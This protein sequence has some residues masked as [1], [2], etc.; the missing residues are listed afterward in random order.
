GVMI[1]Y[2]SS[3]YTTTPLRVLYTVGIQ[4]S[5]KT[6]GKIDIEKVDEAYKTA[7]SN[8]DGSVNF[9]SNL[10]VKAN[11]PTGDDRYDNGAI[12]DTTV[13]FTPSIHNRYYFF[14]KNRQIY[15]DES[16]V[17]PVPADYV[18]DNHLPDG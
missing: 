7:N 11:N 3:R 1:D 17:K 16:C 8:T 5:I 6:D 14:Q 12:G 18:T 2:T 10:Y 15:F 13:Q 4:D 9:Y